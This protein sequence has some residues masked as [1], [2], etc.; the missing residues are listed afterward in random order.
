MFCRLRAA[1][2]DVTFSRTFVTDVP[3]ITFG[4][5]GTANDLR[6]N[7]L[8]MI[9]P[10]S[11]VKSQENAQNEDTMGVQPLR[12]EEIDFCTVTS[13]NVPPEL[14]F[15]G[16]ENISVDHVESLFDPDGGIVHNLVVAH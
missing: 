13:G 6:G 5:L 15:F 4:L 12:G 10:I 11:L 16:I 14:L 2:I 9:L 3:G 1:N 8:D 7:K